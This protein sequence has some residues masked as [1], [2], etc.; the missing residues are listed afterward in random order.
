TKKV[1]LVGFESA[2][3]WVLLA[4]P[5]C[6]DAV[7]R[8]AAD[9]NGFRFDKVRRVDD[10]MML[11][12][13]LKYGGLP[14]LAALTAPGELLM[15]NQRGTGSGLLHPRPK[16]VSAGAAGGQRLARSARPRRPRLFSG[17]SPRSLL[18]PPSRR[19]P[20]RRSR[21]AG[22]VDGDIS[23]TLAGI[24]AGLHGPGGGC[25]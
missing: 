1:D 16:A 11:P 20:L 15:H 9:V 8:T 6:G 24:A 22:S 12:G 14:A 19:Q 23:G 21:Y 17:D 7:A 4:R 2:G 25:H 10:E 13:E 18:L 5:L 3:P